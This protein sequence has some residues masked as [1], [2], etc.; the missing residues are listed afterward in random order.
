MAPRHL[1][2]LLLALLLLQPTAA[3]AAPLQAP[4][5]APLPQTAPC[6]TAVATALAHKGARYV[7][8]AKGPV[9]FDCSGLTWWSYM[10]AGTD[11]GQGTTRQLSAGVAVPCRLDQLAG[12]ATSCWAPGDLAFLI[13]SGGQHVAM[14]VGSG[15]FMDCYN[16]AMGC[17]LHA[18]Q[19]DP[20][21]QDHF[22][23]ARRITSGCEG[24]ANDP[25]APSSTAPTGGAGGDAPLAIPPTYTLDQ[26]PDIL[27][28]TS[29]SVPQCGDCNPDGQIVLAPQAAPSSAGPFDALYPF[30]WLGWAIE[31]ALRKVLCWLLW[32][33]AL[34]AS[35]ASSIINLFIFG[36]N[37]LWRLFVVLWTNLRAALFLMFYGIEQLRE[38]INSFGSFALLIQ[39]WLNAI[40]EIFLAVVQLAAQIGMLL[41]ILALGLLNLIGWVGAL[42]L[43]FLLNI[44]A[45]FS[46]T[47]IPV[48]L[49]PD[50]NII[51]K[52]VRGSLEAI[53]NGF[54]GWLYWL[55]VGSIYFGFFV[56]LS[57]YLSSSIAEE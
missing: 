23:G 8:G 10:Q 1:I 40:L 54:F 21:Y 47:T 35:A 38:F 9:E 41:L 51:Y 48:E 44:L 4:P 56:W 6:V 30:R 7:W 29:I 14:Y 55:L 24:L 11:I 52:V 5:G 27:G 57:R 26:V 15:L 37:S 31:E 2:T 19:N 43:S 32:L 18:V 42:F 20:F 49:T 16:P 12:A 53:K 39:A 13:Y 3:S 33:V 22:A 46:A 45:S 25:G 28:Y 36:L 17:I 50:D 34:L